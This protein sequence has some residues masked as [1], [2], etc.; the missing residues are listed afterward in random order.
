MKDY[1]KEIDPNEGQ[2]IRDMRYNRQMAKRQR[3][4]ARMD[5]LLNNPIVDLVGII[6]FF[7][8]CWLLLAMLS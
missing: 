2:S 7:V 5:A 4:L 3:F 6:S 8:S 1:R